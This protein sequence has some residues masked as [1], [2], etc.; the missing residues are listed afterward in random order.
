MHTS[1]ALQFNAFLWILLVQCIPWNPYCPLYILELCRVSCIHWDC[2]A[3]HAYLGILIDA[4]LVLDVLGSVGIAQRADG[5]II[6]V[7]SRAYVGNH[8]RLCVAA[9]GILQSAAE[10][11]S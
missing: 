2:D 11:N 4:R 8:H 3:S 5:L 6:V 9:Q 7:V 10:L 1:G